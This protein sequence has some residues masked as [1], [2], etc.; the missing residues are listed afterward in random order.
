[1]TTLAHLSDTHLGYANFGRQQLMEDPWHPGIHLRRQAVDLMRGL[2]QAIDVLIE[3]VRPDIVVHSGDLFDTARP[4]PIDVDFA[5]GQFKRLSQ[6]GIPTVVVEGGHSYARDRAQGQVLRLLTHLPL[7]SVITYDAGSVRVGDVLIQGLPF[8]AVALGRRPDIGAVDPKGHNVLVAHACADGLP[9][10][11]SGRPAPALPVRDVAPS[12]QYVALGHFHHFAQVSGTDR[13]FYAGATAM[14][15]SADFN[16][17][18]EFGFNVVVLTADAPNVSRIVTQ[19]VPLHA[20]GLNDA[21]GLS[22]EDVLQFL[23]R[24]AQAV[25]PQGAYVQVLVENL[26]PLARRELS[27][28]EVEEVF[29]GAAAISVS[30][31]V[32]EQRWETVRASLAAA[33]TAETRFAEFVNALVDDALLR[34]EVRALGEDLL[35]RAAEEVGQEDLAAVGADEEGA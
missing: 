1:M 34:A 31:R 2:S 20:F 22:R 26:D 6:A 9:F 3:D 30:L 21:S 15:S 11:Q 16:P 5:M 8:R 13:A 4:S 12:F 27:I 23:T 29:G 33:G 10:F 17:G 18:R 14:V 28:R 7:I 25:P 32:R 19:S 35:V 24:Q